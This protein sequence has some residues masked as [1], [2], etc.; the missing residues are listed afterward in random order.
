MTILTKEIPKWKIEQI[1]Q[2]AEKLK[3]APTIAIVNIKGMPAK[4]FHVLRD[5]L[6]GNVDIKVYKK[7]IIKFA[8]DRVK[9][10]LRDI[11]KL[12]ENLGE[13]P[14][15]IFS[16]LTP[17][18]IAKLL[19][20][21]KAPTFAKAGDIAPR[22]IVIEAGPTPF[23][24]GPMVSELG[25]LGLKVKVEGG[26]I[27]IQQP[28]TIVK[29]GEEISAPV[30]ELLMKLGIQ[31]ME[32]GL[33]LESAWEDGFVYNKE[34]LRFDVNEYLGRLS[35]AASRAFILS[36]GLAYPTKEN[37]SILISKAYNEAKVL[38]LEKGIFVDALVPQ[39]LAKAK[40]EAE[41]LDVYVKEKEGD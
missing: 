24:P 37:I 4:E 35:N 19:A 11:D 30:A 9:N 2:L 18:K 28:T 21:N 1:N 31:P 3:G 38:A 20:E 26:K 36:I 22:D 40:A 23:T 14:A 13:M 27:V 5:K 41:S 8:L 6:R 39:L 12:K 10:E 32:I 17:F 15:L 29:E 33:E 7:T 34:I 16:N 25:K